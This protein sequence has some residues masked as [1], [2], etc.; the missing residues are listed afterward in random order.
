MKAIVIAELVNPET[1]KTETFNLSF[2]CI[3][4][5]KPLEEH[6]LE[7]AITCTKEIQDAGRV[8]AYRIDK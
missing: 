3:L 1:K 5:D 4:H 8:N 2:N 6:T 7:E